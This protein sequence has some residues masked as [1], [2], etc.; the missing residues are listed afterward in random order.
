MIGGSER[1]PVVVVI[2]RY[3]V[4]TTTFIDREIA[5]LRCRGIAVD[6]VALRRPP[7]DMPLSTAQRKLGREVDYALPVQ[8]WHLVAAGLFACTRLRACVQTLWYL[9]TRVHPDPRSRAR[10]LLH[11]GEGVV[12][13]WR[14]RRRAPSELYAHFAD[15]AA[16][17]ALVASRLLDCSYSLAIHAGADL[18]VHPVLLREKIEQAR[19]V[20]TCTEANRTAISA[21][22]GASLGEKV[23]Y[24]RHGL[25]LA[26]YRP[27]DARPGADQDAPPLVL[28]VGQLREK[29]GFTHLVDA[30]ERLRD[31]GHRFTCRIIGE[32]PQRRELEAQI[33]AAQLDDCVV[34]TGAL[35]QDD[36]VAWYRRASVFALPCVVTPDGQVDG[37]PNVVPEAMAMG[38][39]VV[40]SDLPAIRE[41]V[42]DEVDGL[43]VAPGD[44]DA[45]AAAVGRLLD[46]PRFAAALAGAGLRTVHDRFDVDVNVDRLVERMWPDHFDRR[47]A[48]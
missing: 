44:A 10:T 43:L 1:A 22:V 7:A 5:A 35:P 41:L 28:A 14:L 20:V 25:P 32:G 29:K 36:V 26:E 30:C 4:V 6:V 16:V 48:G 39:P 11:F 2:G 23:S 34:V 47:E 3:P 31:R 9:V 12:V 21:R 33:R 46:E 8:W 19:V 27:P 42:T 15:R 38:V 40:S 37:I 13:A 24:I 18:F 17:V 45:L